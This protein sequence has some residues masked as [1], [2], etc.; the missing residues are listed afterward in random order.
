MGRRAIL[1]GVDQKAEALPG[2]FLGET[3]SLEHKRLHIASMDADGAAAQLHAVK[4]HVI[5]LGAHPPGI[6]QQV[7]QVLLI[8]HGEGMVHGQIASFLLRPLKLREVRHEAEAEVVLSAQAQHVAHLQPQGAQGAANHVELVRAEQDEVAVLRVQRPEQLSPLV[9]GEVFLEDGIDLAVF[10][11]E[12]P[13]HALGSALEGMV[14]QVFDGGAGKLLRAALAVEGAHLA[15][16]IRHLAEHG[17]GAAGSQRRHVPDGHA[18]AQVGLVAAVE[19]HALLP[20][21]AGEIVV[22]LPPHGVGKNVLEQLFQVTQNILLLHK[23][24]FHIHLGE[25]RLAVG[26]QVLIPEAPGHLIIPVNAAY[27]QQ[28]LEDLRALGQGIERAGMHAAGHQIVPCAL[29]GGLAQHGGFH[30]IEALRVEEL[31]RRGLNLVAELERLLHGRAAQVKVAVF[32]PQLL[33]HMG[34]VV[35]GIGQGLCLAQHGQAMGP[36]LHLAGEQAGVVGTLVPV[37]NHAGHPH[38]ALQMHALRQAEVRL[39]QVGPVAYHLGH[40]LPVAHVQEDHAAHVPLHLHPAAQRGL[41]THVLPA[42]A[43]A[44]MRSHHTLSISFRRHPIKKRPS[45]LMGRKT[46]LTRYH[47]L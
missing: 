26:A 2:A 28:L 5:R 41:A 45:P 38:H 31:L 18:E 40:A 7:L 23:G 9:A 44:I 25:L 33:P 21:Q 32:Q 42:D 47:P 4:H 10:M 29:G 34:A 46:V 1:E 19:I 8:G 39:A 37:A 6:G 3:Q 27:H 12:N 15:A 16:H 13:R 17:E 11:D 24:H 36:Q 30:L 22:D 20:R 43:A 35:H 14:G